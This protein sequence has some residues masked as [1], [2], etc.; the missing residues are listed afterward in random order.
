LIFFYVILRIFTQFFYVILLRKKNIFLQL[1]K[2]I[3]I[4]AILVDD[5]ELFRLGVRTAM[6]STQPDISIV[7]EAETGA[8]F[9]A[10]LE[11]TTADIV[12]L[13]VN[14]PDMSGLD[15]AQRLKKEKPEMKILIISSENTA[16]VTQAVLTLGVNGFISKRM[17]G[18]D[19]LAE[20]IRSIMSGLE[21]FGKD[22]SEIIYQVYVAKKKTTDVTQEFT[23]QEKTIIEL[24]RK[25]LQSKQIADQLNISPRTVETHKNN[26]FHKLGIN[27]TVEMVQ[28]AIKNGIIYI[29]E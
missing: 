7:G 23:K 3:M 21:Y 8:N 29:N 26:I 9:F 25:G 11:T 5:H 24:C 15:I 18:V 19:V 16:T 27:N 14:L 28:F 1:Q 20:A 2:T 13:D 10:L 12:L 6:Q 17:S 22:I 4:T